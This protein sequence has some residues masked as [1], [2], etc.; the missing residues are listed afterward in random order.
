MDRFTAY[1]ANLHLLWGGPPIPLNQFSV[2]SNRDS[3]N[4]IESARDPRRLT[5]RLTRTSASIGIRVAR[6]VGSLCRTSQEG[7]SASI[8]ATKPRGRLGGGM[9]E[10]NVFRLVCRNRL[11][12]GEVRCL[13]V[14]WE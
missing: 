3:A 12:S 13:R 9:E 14:G 1:F 11:G 5:Q 10:G 6:P 7:S 8:G 4:P 2:R